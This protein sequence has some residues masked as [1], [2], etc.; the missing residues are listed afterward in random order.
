MEPLAP[1]IVLGCPSVTVF[2]A[3]IDSCQAQARVLHCTDVV[4]E[5]SWQHFKRWLT[6]VLC[7]M[8]IPALMMRTYKYSLEVSQHTV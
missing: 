3:Q 6:V 5:Y 4:H 7:A 8:Q 2:T 1:Y